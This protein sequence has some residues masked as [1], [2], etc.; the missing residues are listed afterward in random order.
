VQV[1]SQIVDNHVHRVYICTESDKGQEVVGV[2]TPTDILSLIAGQGGW[3]RRALSAR[4]NGSK[5]QA[6][7]EAAEAEEV[8][9]DDAVAR[10]LA[11]DAAAAAEGAHGGG[12]KAR[13][14][15]AE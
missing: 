3:L 14:E 9:L 13:H 7:A 11:A 4:A 1:L 2:V 12:K 8:L 15:D 6:S 10:A 5:R